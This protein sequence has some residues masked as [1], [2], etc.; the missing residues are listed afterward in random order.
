MNKSCPGMMCAEHNGWMDGVQSMAGPESPALLGG[1]LHVDVHISRTSNR[2]LYFDI[3]VLKII[4]FLPASN[5]V[6]ED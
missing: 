5:S 2:L 3:F 1:K 4:F 6:Q